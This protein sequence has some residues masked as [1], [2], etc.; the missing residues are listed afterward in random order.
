MITISGVYIMKKLPLLTSIVTVLCLTSCTPNK[1]EEKLPDFVWNEEQLEVFH[2]QL[3]GHEIPRPQRELTKF[4]TYAGY[5]VAETDFDN[6]IA[7]E[8]SNQ[9][10]KESYQVVYYTQYDSYT[11]KKYINNTEY[12]SVSFAAIDEE[13]DSCFQVSANLKKDYVERDHVWDEKELGIFNEHL[14]NE[15]LPFPDTTRVSMRYT[16]QP[17]N[18]YIWITGDYNLTVLDRYLDELTKQGFTLSK[19]SAYGIDVARKQFANNRYIELWVAIADE[20]SHGGGIFFEIMAY[21]KHGVVIPMENKHITFGSYPQ[22]EMTSRTEVYAA[23]KRMA[24]E[25]PE[26][27]FP[28]GWNIF[29]DYYG[30]FQPQEY[31]FYKDIIYRGEKYRAIY[32]TE[33]RNNYCG[34]ET[35][36]PAYPHPMKDNGYY[37]NTVYVFKFEPIV[38]EIMKTENG[39]KTVA[40]VNVLDVTHYS[41]LDLYAENYIGEG[42]D[43]KRTYPCVYETSFI[44]SFI[45]NE[46]YNDAFTAEEKAKIQVT[47]VDNSLDSCA[48]LQEELDLTDY[49]IADDFHEY[50]S[51]D[52]DDKMFLFSKKEFLDLDFGYG[53]VDN[54]QNIDLDKATRV[55]TDYALARGGISAYDAKNTIYE[56]SIKFYLRSPLIS[57]YYGHLVFLSDEYSGMRYGYTNAG[58][59]LGMFPGMNIKID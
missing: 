7:E 32:N 42:E 27:N 26:T 11:A 39:V 18:N 41:M 52:T 20:S 15:V 23:V 16:N 2:S 47:H 49:L 29:T 8:Y 57:G 14:N 50:L 4:S 33:L 46:F 36:N 30:E 54:W 55:G 44:R 31:G 19:H 45:N 59:A 53:D 24:G 48:P 51:K 17:S 1:K 28:N 56:D 38:W 40:P 43:A 37:A 6:T 35:G 58:Q 13:E 9:L 21:D 22:T 10:K 34:Q 5:V 25:L 12:I 3:K